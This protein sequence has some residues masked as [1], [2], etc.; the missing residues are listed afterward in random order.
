VLIPFPFAADQHQHRNAEA[1]R[2]AEAAELI[3]EKKA[4]PEE[5]ARLIANLFA[6]NR[7]RERMASASQSVLP[8]GAAALV[9]KVLEEASR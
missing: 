1:F 4:D 7:R 9:A 5:F 2:D 6:D 3:E 8:R